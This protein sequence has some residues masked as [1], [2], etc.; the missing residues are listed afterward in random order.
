M[1]NQ[2]CDL[3]IHLCSFVGLIYT[4]TL[5]CFARDVLIFV[6]KEQL[7]QPP[8]LET[9]G[10]II[11]D[12]GEN[13]CIH[14]KQ[15]KV[16]VNRFRTKSCFHITIHILFRSAFQWQELKYLLEQSPATPISL[17]ITGVKLAG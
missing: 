14:V 13:A 15:A 5:N 7:I 16:L 4:W 11:L 10:E 17:R 12:T 8:A 2:E 3:F 6:G 1:L 9:S